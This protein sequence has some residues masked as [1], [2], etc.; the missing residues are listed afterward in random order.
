[1]CVVFGIIRVRYIDWELKR[2]FKRE[3]RVGNL[4]L[5]VF[6]YYGVMDVI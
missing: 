1:M 3:I 2:E 4:I 5:F 6:I